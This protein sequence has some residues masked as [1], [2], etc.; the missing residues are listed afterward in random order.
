MSAPPRTPLSL[1]PPTGPAPTGGRRQPLDRVGIPKALGWG[2]VGVL[3]FM[4]RA[5]IETS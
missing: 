3:F 2:H 1:S 4:T 5:G